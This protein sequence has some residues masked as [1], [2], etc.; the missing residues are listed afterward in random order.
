M[1]ILTFECSPVESTV[2]IDVDMKLVGSLLKQIA[3]AERLTILCS[4]GQ[5]G[6]SVEVS[7]VYRYTLF[8]KKVHCN[9]M[10]VDAG[11]VD[12]ARTVIVVAV[13]IW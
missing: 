1:S 4:N 8:Q 2:A 10:S 5:R 9:H 7:H 13:L 3:D 6:A 12:G 11:P